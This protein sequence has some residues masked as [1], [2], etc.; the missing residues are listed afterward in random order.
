MPQNDT[1]AYY[2]KI[3][4]NRLI[5]IGDIHGEIEKLNSLLDKLNLTKSDTVVFLGDYIDVGHNPKAVIERLIELQK[6]TNCIF[7]MGNHEDIL[8]KVLKT[9]NQD[10]VEYWLSVGGVTTFD[11]YGD[12][13][14]PKSHVQFLKNLKFYYQTE[15]YF[16]VHAG[17][18]P[19]KPL[20]EQE[21]EDFL[22]IRDNFIYKKHQL[23]QKVIFGHTPFDAPYIDKDKI[24]INTNSGRGENE[25]LTALICDE[26][27]FVTSDTL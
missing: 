24:G 6:E 3:M 20:E 12:F 25:K 16:F 10:D 19:D 21:K 4:K 11:S 26:N 13:F 1:V 27:I 9:K 17:I 8:L 14:L 7:L 18:R 5:A 23:K 15:K 2:N 22:W